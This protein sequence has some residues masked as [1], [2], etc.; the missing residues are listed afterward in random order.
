MVS[1]KAFG[2]AWK[3]FERVSYATKGTLASEEYY[4]AHA[5][6]NS[7]LMF[8]VDLLVNEETRELRQHLVDQ[9][10]KDRR[11]QEIV[12][13]AQ[14]PSELFENPEFV[15]YLLA[16]PTS[17][18]VKWQSH[19][20]VVAEMLLNRYVD[21]YLMYLSELLFEIF[22]QRPETLRSSEQVTVEFVLN[23]GS[24]E[25]L[26]RSLAERKV[27]SLSYSS[28]ADLSNYFLKHFGLMLFEGAQYQLVKLAIEVRNICTHNRGRVSKI[29]IERMGEAFD[30]IDARP[31]VGERHPVDIELVE[32][33][34]LVFLDGVQR[35]DEEA[36]T[37]LKL[38]ERTFIIEQEGLE[39][40][41]TE[42]EALKSPRA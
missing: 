5:E 4:R 35:T 21:N 30:T 1:K 25:E 12:T 38:E 28:F 17:R 31:K 20:R 42:A 40:N 13:A 10:D 14:D 18:L 34:A 27:L 8:V 9:Y 19:G 2:E 39:D 32:A 15:A 29:F 11:L 33:V 41:G 24:I 37:K 16:V 36:R 22:T 26:V 7:F 6:L 23:Q 3:N